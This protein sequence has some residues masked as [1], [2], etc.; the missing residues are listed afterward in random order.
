MA[1]KPS[2]GGG[3]PKGMSADDHRK[4]AETLSARASL[5]HAKARVL[6]AKNPPKKDKGSYNP[7]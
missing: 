5:H 7:Y 3:K 1:K 4:M 2:K 6:E